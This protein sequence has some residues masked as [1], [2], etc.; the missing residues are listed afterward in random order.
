MC[1]SRRVLSQRRPRLL[2]LNRHQGETPNSFSMSA[3]IGCV[4]TYRLLRARCERPR[5]RAP[6][7][8]HELATPI[9]KTRS[10][11]TI[12]KRVGLAKRPKPAK[13]YRFHPPGSAAKA[14]A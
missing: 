13:G 11:G 7:Q 2:S 1:G 8:H 6:E 3:I 4:K 5:R 10:H 14:G 12:A 9:K